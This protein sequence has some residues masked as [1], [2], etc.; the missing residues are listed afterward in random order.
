MTEGWRSD[1][2][3]AARVAEQMKRLVRGAVNVI[4]A[5]EL[6][7]R[8]AASIRA[9]RPLRVKLGVDPTSSQLHLGFTVVLNK[10]RAFQDCGHVAVL[11]IGDATALVGDPTGRNQTRPRLSQAEV[12]ENA[13]TYLKQAG[14]VL[15][16]PKAEVRRNGEWLGKLGFHGMIE[17]L[18]KR[19]AAQILERE[20]F[21]TR[22]DSKVPIYL[23]EMVYP[24]LQGR[25]SVEVR[26]DVELGGTDQL[27]N[28]LVGRDLQI[29]AG[30]PPQ[31]CMTLPILPG[32][33]GVQKMSKSYGNTIGL[34]EPPEEIFGKVMSVPDGL[35]R[36]YFTLT[37]T[38]AEPEIE[39]HLAGHPRDAKVALARALVTRYHG[40]E[41]AQAAADRFRRVFSEKQVPEEMPDVTVPD[42]ATAEASIGVLDLIVLAKFAKSKS[43]ARRLVEQGG[44]SIDG[45]RV[46]DV[47]ARVRVAGGEVLRVGK[48]Q[49]A[50]LRRG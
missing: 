29:D 26:A 48:L 7:D 15:D 49:F 6:E 47:G 37:T 21:R 33:D 43:E 28:L 13:R 41:A 40:E 39:K 10:L 42:A 18:A 3:L 1:P 25:D 22:W 35:V 5:G 8:L 34:T 2:A 16:L 31:I 36:D 24:L 9:G 27:F 23:H 45:N 12:E 30:Q 32:L 46:P 4:S 19:T 44:V 11:I 20:D 17:L 14:L 50:R 38:V